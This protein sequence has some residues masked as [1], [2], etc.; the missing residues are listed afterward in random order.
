[1]KISI[2][3]TAAHGGSGGIDKYSAYV[4]DAL[5]KN[6]LIIKLKDNFKEKVD[7]TFLF[8]VD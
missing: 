8:K 2:I 5:V 6:K 3:T 7:G 4:I 1:M